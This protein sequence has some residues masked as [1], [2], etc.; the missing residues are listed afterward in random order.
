MVA[1]PLSSLVDAG[2]SPVPD[3][4]TFVRARYTRAALLPTRRE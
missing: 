2:W 4:W 3:S 1:A